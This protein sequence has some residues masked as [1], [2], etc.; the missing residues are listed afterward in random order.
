[1]KTNIFSKGLEFSAL[2]IK[3]LKD[4]Y[5]S[6]DDIHCNLSNLDEDYRISVIMGS[7]P[8]YYF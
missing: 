5:N 3:K 4:Y 1:M 7:A 8:F 2:L 6:Y